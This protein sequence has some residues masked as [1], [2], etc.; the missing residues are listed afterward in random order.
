MCRIEDKRHDSE[1][2]FTM[3]H[4]FIHVRIQAFFIIIGVTQY[5]NIQ[6]DSYGTYSLPM[7]C[8]CGLMY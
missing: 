1:F 2:V 8:K 5:I 3:K 6:Y 4:V 7:G